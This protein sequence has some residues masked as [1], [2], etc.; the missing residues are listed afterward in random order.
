MRS[1]ENNVA[2]LATT[3]VGFVDPSTT[4]QTQQPS[5]ADPYFLQIC[6]ANLLVA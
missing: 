2:T 1:H 6:L 3:V 4:A 5:S